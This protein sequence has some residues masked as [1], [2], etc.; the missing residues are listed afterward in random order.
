MIAIGRRYSVIN[1]LWYVFSLIITFFKAYWNKKNTNKSLSTIPVFNFF[2]N[3][4]RLN[5]H[6]GY[7]LLNIVQYKH[8]YQGII[9]ISANLQTKR[10]LY[11]RDKWWKCKWL[12]AWLV[13][14]NSC[15]CILPIYGSLACILVNSWKAS[16]GL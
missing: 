10:V 9:N 15:R 2:N 7:Q 14:T 8:D 11:I 3:S 6:S 5:T 12:Y 16:N 1:P 4:S 13:P